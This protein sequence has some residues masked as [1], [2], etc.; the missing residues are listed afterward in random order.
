MPVRQTLLP[1]YSLRQI[2]AITTALGF[3]FLIASYGVRGASWAGGIALGL[4]SVLAAL[5]VYGAFFALVWGAAALG[6]WVK[7]RA[8]TSGE[9]RGG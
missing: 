7:G 4:L 2:L 8:A 6:S 9:E 1:R 5:L 3:V